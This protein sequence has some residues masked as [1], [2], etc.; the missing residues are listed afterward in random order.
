MGGRPEDS[1]LGFLVASLRRVRGQRERFTGHRR[2]MTQAELAKKIGVSRVSIAHVETGRKSMS[3]YHFDK[4]CDQLD[5]TCQGVKFTWRLHH[6]GDWAYI[7]IGASLNVTCRST[8]NIL[9]HGIVTCSS[10]GN[11]RLESD[12]TGG[13]TGNISM[14]A[15]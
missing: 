15:Q 13:S 1:A 2:T 10:T 5:I 7:P 9:L 4:M 3:R 14:E 6:M 11:F 8:G 12:V